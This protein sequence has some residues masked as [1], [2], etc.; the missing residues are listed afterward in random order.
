MKLTLNKAAQTC[1]RS[2]ST[3]LDAIKSGRL[4]APKDE[5]GRYEIDP[6]E[7]HRVFPFKMPDQ[8]ENQSAEPDHTAQQNHL[9]NSVLEREVELLRQM[10][11]KAETNAD[12]WR[13]M[14]ERQQ[15][16]LQ[17]LRPKGFFRR[18]FN[19]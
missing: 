14:A 2:K 8:S 11:E 18:L 3:I 16:L 13:S 15:I 12:H 1:S 10:L 7:L 6:S 9:N 19:R 17:D 4:T 5:K